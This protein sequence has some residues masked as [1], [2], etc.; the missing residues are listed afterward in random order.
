MQI[1]IVYQTKIHPL[2]LNGEAH[3]GEIIAL[4]QRVA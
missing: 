2:H 1:E 4:A 3:A